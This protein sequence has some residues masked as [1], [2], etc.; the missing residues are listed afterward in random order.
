MKHKSRGAKLAEVYYNSMQEDEYEAIEQELKKCNESDLREAFG[1]NNNALINIVFC[2]YGDAF[3]YISQDFYKQMFSNISQQ[4]RDWLE[5]YISD[6]IYHL[7]DDIYKDLK[8]TMKYYA[9]FANWLYKVRCYIKYSNP[10]NDSIRREYTFI[11]E[12]VFYNSYIGE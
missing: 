3:E 5:N 8:N 2:G 1:D 11:M 4:D 6:F 12:Q 10:Q 7:A 9:K